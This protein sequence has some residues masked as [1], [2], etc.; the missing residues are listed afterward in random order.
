MRRVFLL[1]LAGLQILLLAGKGGVRGNY[2]ELE[3]LL[4]IQTMGIDTR[5]NGV[6][7]CLAAKGDSRQGVKRLRA[8]ASSVTAAIERIRAESFEEELFSAHINQLLIGEKAAEAGL[9]DMLADLARSPDLRLDLPLYVLREDTAENAV[10]TVG[11]D[12]R[13]IC[14]VMDTV[15]QGALRRGGFSRTTAAQIL[16]DQ[17]RFGAALI[18]AMRLMPAAEQEGETGEKAPLTASPE[19]Y[20]VLRGGKLCRYLTPEQ[21]VAVGFLKNE[22]AA[23][24]IPLRDS[25]G[26]TA[27]LEIQNGSCRI[28]P[29]FSGEGQLTG[30]KIAAETDASVVE[31]GAAGDAAYSDMLCARLEE[32][33]AREI[34]SVLRV[35]R[36][37]KADFLGLAA[38]VEKA[39]P[40]AYQKLDRDF[41]EL[42]PEL[43]LEITVSARL[44]HAN[45]RKEI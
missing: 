15:E 7:V 13:G 19:G 2:R 30:L 18:C 20:A 6:T 21:A 23:A 33:L 31:Q 25:Y 14:D 38:R 43:E 34:E 39:D 29:V 32:Y 36:D 42:L 16:A 28:R 24:E 10:M 3:Q 44:R 9:D 40:S 45:D 1:F 17:D 41:S 37:L 12:T 4:V 26:R 8:S 22:T 11:D 27:V 35:S 5:A